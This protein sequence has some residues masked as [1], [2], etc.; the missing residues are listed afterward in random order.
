MCSNVLLCCLTLAAAVGI[1]GV[2]SGLAEATPTQ[3]S[4]TASPGSG[5]LN[6]VSCSSPTNCM[7]VGYDANGSTLVEA[8]D[9]TA[10]SVQS[11]P[12]QG[13]GK[14]FLN[15]VSCVSPASCVAVGDSS[16]GVSGYQTLIESWDGTEWSIVPSPGT[17]DLV[18]VLRGVSCTSPSS[19]VAVGRTGGKTLVESWDGTVWSIVPSPSPSMYSDTLESVSCSNSTS[20]LAVG[21]YNT[22][23]QVL[24]LVESWDGSTWSV[25]PSPNRHAG[26]GA[27]NYLNGISCINQ[28]SCMAVGHYSLV[29]DKTLTESWNGTSWAVVSSPN[30]GSADVLNGVSCISVTNCVAVGRYG[31]S[32]GTGE[33]LIQSWNGLAWSIT[34]S[35][36]PGS[37]DNDLY[38]VVCTT[39]TTCV[40]TGSSTDGMGISGLV[41]TGTAPPT[42][43]SFTPASGAPG[44]PVT[45][46]G[47]ELAG[48]TILTFNGT[49]AAIVTDKSAKITT[50]VPIG[51]T[52]GK[53]RVT[54][55]SGTA[56]SNTNFKVT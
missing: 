21:S 39:A 24:T 25:V 4:T 32:T 50:T 30:M 51:A 34:P 15:G 10:W 56:T 20:C 3:W 5:Q 9:G 44:S 22:Q 28:T 38:S 49:P 42:I 35:P 46:K 36:S 48:A 33:T 43:T 6:G 31:T 37:D 1:A 7:T 18:S 26:H 14:N 41:E 11:S 17:S 52:T 55:P 19:C 40:A 12:D 13:S 53:I 8:W 2:P 27:P 29:E 54:T 23:T 16:S 45:I 47:T